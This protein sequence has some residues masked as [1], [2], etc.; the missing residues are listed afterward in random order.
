LTN[1]FFSFPQLLRDRDW[2][3]ECVGNDMRKGERKPLAKQNISNTVGL[4]RFDPNAILMSE[5]F[6][7]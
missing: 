5:V 2:D 6:S 3:P 1:S 7:I 4:A